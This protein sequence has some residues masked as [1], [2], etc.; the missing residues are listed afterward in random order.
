MAVDAIA[1]PGAPPLTAGPPEAQA[2][3]GASSGDGRAFSEVIASVMERPAVP[4]EGA[5]VV[6][7]VVVPPAP[8]VDLAALLATGGAPAEVAQD[9]MPITQELRPDRDAEAEDAAAAL[10]AFMLG[11]VLPR[12]TAAVAMTTGGLASAP[13]VTVGVAAASLALTGTSADEVVSMPVTSPIDAQA[14]AAVPQEPIAVPVSEYGWQ[15]VV[16]MTVN[17][18][19]AALALPKP[20]TE[21]AP[22]SSA[23]VAVPASPTP[24]AAV[25]AEPVQAAVSSEQAGEVASSTLPANETIVEQPFE[26]AGERPAPEHAD[27]TPTSTPYAAT[28]VEVRAAQVAEVHPTLTVDAT[29]G[30]RL[31]SRVADSVQAATLTGD[32]ELRIALNP[33]DLGQLTVHITEHAQGGVTVA[34]HA[35]S[36]EAH[37]L[38][39]QQLPA[40]RAGLEQREVRVE[41]LQVEQQAPSAGLGWADSGQQRSNGGRD[42]WA[43]RDEQ[44]W[45]PIA[46]MG[47]V[48]SDA[49]VSSRGSTEV[50][51]VDLRA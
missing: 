12:P 2:S 11:G 4:A 43:S 31:A 47:G 42:A 6:T 45:S 7:E 34:I 1:L 36:A 26:R 50:G 13:A 39:Q 9:L 28:Q 19:E 15:P 5:P 20:G 21:G 22:I 41:R 46:A 16:P 32:R 37:D 17:V 40:L 49:A 38:L 14:T 18:P 29:D 33:P 25:A 24:A 10:A 48:R 27:A 3:P 51:R 23:A 30:P 8:G 35:S 44:S